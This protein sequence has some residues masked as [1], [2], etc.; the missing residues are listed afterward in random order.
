MDALHQARRGGL[1][2]DEAGWAL[3]R[4]LLEH[5]ESDLARARRG[6]LGGARR[7][8]GTSPIPR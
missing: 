4:A 7:R 2:G 3:Q 6:H 5:L 1:A 8:A